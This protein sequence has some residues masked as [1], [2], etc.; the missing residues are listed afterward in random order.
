MGK[1]LTVSIAA[2]NVEAYI[3]KTLDSFCDDIIL[4][5]NEIEVLIIDDGSRDKT[6]EIVQE[7][8]D[9]Y[10]TVFRLIKKENG[11][12]GS[13]INRGILEATGKYFRVVDGDDYVNTKYFIEFLK[14]IE[15]VNT[16]MVVADF[17]CVDSKGNTYV[18]NY[19]EAHGK[20]CFEK[21]K[22]NM[23]YDFDCEKFN[24]VLFGLSTV[25]IKT[26]L[27]RKAKVHITENCFY[28]DIEFIV[29]CLILAKTFMYFK[30]PVYMYFKDPTGNNSVS[31]TNM[32]KNIAMQKKVSLRCAQI[33]NTSCDYLQFNRKKIILDRI[34]G[35]ISSTIR[36]YLLMQNSRKKIKKFDEELMNVSKELWFELKRDNFINKIR[37]MDYMLVPFM[38][39]MYKGYLCIKK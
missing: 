24:N 33:Y 17:R 39:V 9:K 13:T 18:D 14:Y 23:V 35:I 11:G 7:Y 26:E 20:G 10:P 37:I 19:I 6:C 21:L 12:H 36:T 22:D 3:K 16:D 15:K 32:I 8:V 29:W 27:L 1:L 31:K 5:S 2:Y 28:V 4:E 25:T 34:A 30:H 38:R